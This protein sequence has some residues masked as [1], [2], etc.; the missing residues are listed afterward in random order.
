VRTFVKDKKD[1]PQQ[2]RQK[3]LGNEKIGKLLYKLS[4]PATIGMMVQ[5]LYNLVDAVFVGRGVGT[6]GIGGITI[7]FPIQMIIMA[8]AL[9]IG[10]GGA[11]IISRRMGEKNQEGAAYTFGNMV[12]LSLL[13]SVAILFTGLFFMNPI[14]RLFGA[15]DTL[16]PFAKDY[17]GTIIFGIPFVSFTMATNNAAR[18]EGNAKV[19]MVTM[20]IGAVLNIILDPVFIFLLNMGV[21]GAA[22]ATIISQGTS[23]TFLFFYF[24]SGKSEIRVNYSYLRFRWPIMKEIFAIGASAFARAASASIMVALVNNILSRFGGD[25]GIAAFGIIF[26]ISSFVFMPMIG[27]T[28]GLQPILGFNYGA[29]QYERVKKSFNI[30]SISATLYAFICFII[31]MAIPRVIL[32]A[33]S[34]D[35]KLLSVGKSALRYM[36]LLMPLQGYQVVGSGLFQA[37][38]KALE[39]FVLSLA[40]QMLFL[41]PVLIVLP[42]LLGITGV[43]LSFPFSDGLSFTLTLILVIFQMRKIDQSIGSPKPALEREPVKA[44]T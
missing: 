30:A 29:R 5:A 9:T 18:S 28:Q 21:K 37:L 27:I 10:I 20:L 3:M 35:P 42:L 38:G 43:W 31:L 23:A 11:S 25:T 44:E 7:A 39:A 24:T 32:G 36:V 8:F 1:I 15:T 33:F 34:N 17:F 40:R 14:L 4:I 16:L 22:L 26:R 12:L 6:L 13:I 2:T 41:L 19:A